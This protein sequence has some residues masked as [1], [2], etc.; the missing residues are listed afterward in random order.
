MSSRHRLL[1]LPPAL[2]CVVP[3]SYSDGSRVSNSFYVDYPFPLCFLAIL[4]YLSYLP[5]IEGDRYTF[6]VAYPFPLCFLDILY[7]LS[8]LPFIEGDNICIA[9]QHLAKFDDSR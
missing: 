4:Y 7:Y 9:T 6:Y 2:C 3:F 8:Y 1:D 5:F